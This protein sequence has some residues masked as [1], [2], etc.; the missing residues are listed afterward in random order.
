[1]NLPVL[2]GVGLLITAVA[3]A[4]YAEGEQPVD[5]EPTAKVQ[6][7]ERPAVRRNRSMGFEIRPELGLGGRRALGQ[8][9]LATR[10]EPSMARV[11]VGGFVRTP[12]PMEFEQGLTLRGA[13][14]QAGGANVFGSMRRVKLIRGGKLRQFD[15]TDEKAKPFR[16][17]PRDTVEVPQK[18]LIG[19]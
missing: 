5:E 7:S 11:T 17:E 15:L 18:M 4:A 13:I 14:A 19:R 9:S 8:N 3:L 6:L 2:G 12:G 16:L 10:G 1:M